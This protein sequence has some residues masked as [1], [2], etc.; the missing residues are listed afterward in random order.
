[1]SK[2]QQ[3]RAHEKTAEEKRSQRRPDARIRRTHE[4]LGRALIELIRDKPINEVT[5]QDVLDRASVGR[6]TFYLH[7]RDKNDLLFSQLENFLEFMST[8]LTARKEVSNRVVPLTEM[9]EHI[10]GQQRMYQ[11][12]AESE[13]LE[14]FFDLAQDY[15]THGIE[16]RLK[17]SKRTSKFSQRELRARSVALAG[18]Y[19]ALLR[20]WIARGANESPVE[21][22]TLFHRMVWYG[23]GA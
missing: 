9:F 4:R 19:L 11:A 10:G 7:Y 15:F 12:L 8:L 6:S 13:R 5:V 18:S 14:D 2:K 20:W 1:M 3:L 23:L 22:D 16:R 17:D 21:L